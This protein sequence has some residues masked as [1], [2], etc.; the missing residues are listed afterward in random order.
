MQI[1]LC[2]NPESVKLKF[3]A[4]TGKAKLENKPILFPFLERKRVN[5]SFDSCLTLINE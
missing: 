5:L 2:K 1:L 4:K 3:E